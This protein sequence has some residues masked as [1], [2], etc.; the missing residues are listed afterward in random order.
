MRPAGRFAPSPT[1]SLH[2]GNGYTAL[3]AHICALSMGHQ[4][5]LRVDDLDLR[6]LS[7]GCEEGQIQDLIWMGLSYHEGPTQGAS[8]RR[9]SSV[10]A[11]V[12]QQQPRAGRIAPW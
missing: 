2:V 10:A 12:V 6:S 8:S 9:S 5:I 4:S 3:L 7:A 1:G 11:K